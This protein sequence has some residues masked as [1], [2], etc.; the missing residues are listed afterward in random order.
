M[1]GSGWERN[2]KL[3]AMRRTVSPLPSGVQDA[4]GFWVTAFQGPAE[5]SVSLGSSSLQPQCLD[6]SLARV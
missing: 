2:C 3:L 5:S 4:W 1:I 6:I